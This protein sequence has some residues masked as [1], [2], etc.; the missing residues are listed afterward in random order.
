MS[1]LVPNDASSAGLPASLRM[2]LDVAQRL[3]HG[4]L[5]ITMPDGRAFRF[6]GR[7]PGPDATL[8][9]HHP[10]A[11]RRLLLGGTIGFAESF[12]EGD[13]ETPD[14]TALLELA[15]ANDDALTKVTG[16]GR[17]L[18]LVRRLWHVWHANTRS[19][20]KRNIAYHY[21]L[22]NQFY[23]RWLD[24]TMTYS[25]AVF[26]APQQE[27]AVAQANK[28]RAIAEKLDVR[29]NQKVLEI[30]C[31]WG[32]F[33]SFIAR[34]FGCKVTAITVSKE[35]LAY[36]QERIQRE[37][38]GERVEARFLDYRDLAG[39]FDRI[40]SIEMFEA[41]GEKYWPAFF[42]KVRE[43][44][45]PGG[46]AALQVITIADRWYD[47][48]R[49]SVDY[50]QRYI[51]PGGMLPSVSALSSEIRQAGLDLARQDFFGPDYART[52][53][54]WRQRFVTA[55]PEIAP[56]GFDARFKRMWEFYLAYCEAGFRAQT[57]DVTQV[58][59]VRR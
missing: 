58:A 41:V 37:G 11:I 14:L 29:P 4:T 55:W 10:R 9:I 44:L 23:E 35:Q 54:E 31:G 30:G 20:S 13:W 15:C 38:L 22:G 36:T 53:A 50:I 49:R 16:G 2:F 42:G 48:Y 3:D 32:G 25:S 27:L 33:A 39:R 17:V 45:E 40:A 51:F 5:A 56:M 21:D 24:P 47:S 1:A 19:G 7:K 12:M 8:I 34:E 57:I 52:L 26:T 59:L 46:R 43:S 18:A 28:Y 6:A